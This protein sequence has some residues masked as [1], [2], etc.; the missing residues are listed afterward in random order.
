MFI[1]DTMVCTGCCAT[2]DHIVTYLFKKVTNKGQF[3]FLNQ[4]VIFLPTFLLAVGKKVRGS[5][6]SAEND[7]LVAVIKVDFQNICFC[8]LD[9]MIL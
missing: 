6:T 9:H 4:F 1:T 8:F 2:L 3:L 5:Q 7:P